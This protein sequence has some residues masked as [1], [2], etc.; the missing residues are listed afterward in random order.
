VKIFHKW[1]DFFFGA[2]AKDCDGKFDGCFSHWRPTK[3]SQEM[4]NWSIAR[5]A[6]TSGRASVIV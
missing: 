4:R 2:V 1:D 6:D 3:S 5:E